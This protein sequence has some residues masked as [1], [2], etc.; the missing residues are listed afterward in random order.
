MREPRRAPEIADP[1]PMPAQ[2]RP[3]KA[4]QRDMF[5]NFQLPSHD[6]LD[7]APENSAPKLDKMALERNSSPP[8][9]SR[10]AGWSDWPKT[11]RAT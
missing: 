6:L 7:D 2:P 3:A 4:K 11:S 8:R 9:A 1:A 5:A 10:R